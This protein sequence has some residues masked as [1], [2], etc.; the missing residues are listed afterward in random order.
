MLPPQIAAAE[1]RQVIVRQPLPVAPEHAFAWFTVA[2]RLEQWFCDTAVGAVAVDAEL[3]CTWLDEDGET[4]ERRGRWVALDAPNLLILQWSSDD[5]QAPGEVLRV[6]IA[7]AD[8]PDNS[9]G[10]VVT[11]IS[12]LLVTET[13][14]SPDVLVEA[15]TTGWN[16]ALAELG[17]LLKLQG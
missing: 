7:P 6:A 1:R 15:V 8:L 5:A 11:V 10:C 2:E 17:E 14:F 13:A 12:P 3:H 16:M 9:L 4:W